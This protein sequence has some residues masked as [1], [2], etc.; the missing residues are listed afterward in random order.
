MTVLH[1]VLPPE[2]PQGDQPRQCGRLRLHEIFQVVPFLKEAPRF[3]FFQMLS[4]ILLVDELPCMLDVTPPSIQGVI[5][6]LCNLI[7]GGTPVRLHTLP[8]N[9]VNDLCKDLLRQSPED[10]IACN[11]FIEQVFPK[12]LGHAFGSLLASQHN[13]TP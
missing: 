12:L 1:G 8:A 13:C 6:S 4:E 3:T 10:T 5:V 7:E 2:L 11:E 9:Q